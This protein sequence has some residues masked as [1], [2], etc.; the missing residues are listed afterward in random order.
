MHV[1]PLERLRSERQSAATTATSA[2][3]SRAG[4]WVRVRSKQEILSTLD[5]NGR[6]D[7][8]PFMPQMFQYCGRKA[9]VFK[10]AHKTCDT[11]AGPVSG[12]VSRR[13]PDGVHLE[14]RCDGKAHGGCQA[15]C[16][17]FW[18]EAWLEPIEVGSDGAS[19]VINM[20]AK[21]CCSEDDVLR[22]TKAERDSKELRY[23]CQA[24]ELHKFSEPIKWWDARQYIED[25][26]SANTPLTQMLRTLVYSVFYF[27][28]LANRN[29][30]GRPARWL[31]GICTK[32]VGARPMR[33]ARGNIPLDQPT[34][35]H[36]L[37]LVPGDLVRVKPFEEI[38]NTINMRNSNRGLTF[39][40]EMVM[41]C[42]NTYRV[43]ARVQRFID[44]ATGRMKTLKTP[45]VILEGA[46]CRACYSD[47]RFFCPRSIFAWWREIWLE[48]IADAPARVPIEESN[49][50]MRSARFH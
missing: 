21:A 26:T 20:P 40:A 37:D 45:A 5:P 28:T 33:R 4:D 35:R 39:D 23:A 44:E 2:E 9:R 49:Q 41:F 25:Y 6:L 14:F 10:R 38:L 32:I 12:Y 27:G 16:L 36:D 7:G 30:L 24:T 11:V 15:A 43:R 29:T 22:A 17:L 34:P 19:Q 1:Y 47:Q 8:M 42:G 13:V 46:Y 3:K 31:Y 18:K 48:K 50:V